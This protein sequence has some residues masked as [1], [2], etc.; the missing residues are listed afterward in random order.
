MTQYYGVDAVR[1]IGKKLS[2]DFPKKKPF[3]LPTSTLVCILR[4]SKWEI[5][6]DVSTKTVYDDIWDDYDC[7]MWVSGEL[8]V[9]TAAQVAQCPDTGRRPLEN[10]SP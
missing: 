8:Y 1:R 6:A 3:V 9:L 2:D 7:G 4:H 5:A 10:T